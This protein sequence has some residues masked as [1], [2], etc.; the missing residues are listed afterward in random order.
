MAV[1]AQPLLLAV[2]KVPGLQESFGVSLTLSN[3]RF[4]NLM[5]NQDGDYLT[6][7]PKIRHLTVSKVS[8]LGLGFF[9]DK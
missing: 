4:L 7:V 3:V 8:Q 9:S 5:S 6:S 2:K 1:I